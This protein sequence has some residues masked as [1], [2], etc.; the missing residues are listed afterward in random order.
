[1]TTSSKSFRGAT[2][3]MS[4]IKADNPVAAKWLHS[5]TEQQIRALAHQHGRKGALTRDRTGAFSLDKESL[6][7][8][9]ILLPD[10]QEVAVEMNQR[11]A[12]HGV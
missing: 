9:L 5:L 4:Q 2:K 10:V 1:M 7:N 11:E 6:I 3:D 8:C 12:N